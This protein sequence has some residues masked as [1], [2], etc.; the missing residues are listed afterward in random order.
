MNDTTLRYVEKRITFLQF[1]VI[2]PHLA[3]F[4]FHTEQSYKYRHTTDSSKDHPPF[5]ARS[6]H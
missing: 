6:R 3:R 2:S 5:F 4:P 1:S